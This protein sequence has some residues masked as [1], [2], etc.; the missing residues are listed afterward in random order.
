MCSEPR[1]FTV[2]NVQL[3]HCPCLH[4]C[5]YI[6][7]IWPAGILASFCWTSRPADWTPKCPTPWCGM[8]SKLPSKAAPSLLPSISPRTLC[9]GTWH[10]WT[11]RHWRV[12]CVRLSCCKSELAQEAVF[13]RFDKVLLLETGRVAYYGEVASLRG[14]LSNLGFACPQGQLS[15]ITEA[16]SAEIQMLIHSYTLQLII[17]RF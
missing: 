17:F 9:L 4:V 14:S 11:F 8:S 6:S 15:W 12:W 3:W 10:D 5:V 16:C 13:G 2:Y 7:L 1:K